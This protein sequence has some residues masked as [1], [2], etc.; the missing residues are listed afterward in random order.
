MRSKVFRVAEN[1]ADRNFLRNAKFT[2]F[3]SFIDFLKR[4]S[5]TEISWVF[6][7]RELGIFNQVLKMSN[8]FK[9]AKVSSFS[10][11]KNFAHFLGNFLEKN[12][13]NFFFQEIF[14]KSSKGRNTKWK[15]FREK[16]SWR[17]F[18]EVI[19]I[20]AKIRTIRKSTVCF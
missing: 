10:K 2:K 6:F 14:S 1:F 5:T 15:K 20:K 12:L 16:K 3:S 7:H 17:F 8:L 4:C 19:G 13:K 18:C 9:Q 11:K